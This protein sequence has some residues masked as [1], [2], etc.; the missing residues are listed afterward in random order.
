ML[1]KGKF[2]L[3][4]LFFQEKGKLLPSYYKANFQI[5]P[6]HNVLSFRLN[7]L[8]NEIVCYRTPVRSLANLVANSLTNWLTHC[9]L[10][11]LTDVT[12]WPSKMTN[13]NFLMLLV[14]LMLMLRNVLPT[15]W[16]RFWSCGLVDILNLN[17]GHNIQAEVWSR[18]W[19]WLLVKSS[20]LKVKTLRLMFGWAFEA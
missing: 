1:L 18:F 13:Q 8:K 14:L 11:D 5:F 7:Q 9:Y 19:T 10:L 12:L 15:V 2:V 3:Q 17:F 20:K 4:H 16:S 6:P